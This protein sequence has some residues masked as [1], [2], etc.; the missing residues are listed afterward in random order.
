MD[1]LRFLRTGAIAMPAALAVAT[2]L[3]AIAR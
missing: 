2:A 1:A 3:L